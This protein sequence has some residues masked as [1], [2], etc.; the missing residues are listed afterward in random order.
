MVWDGFPGS[1]NSTS[2]TAIHDLNGRSFQMVNHT[3]AANVVIRGVKMGKPTAL[4][5]RNPLDSVCSLYRRWSFLTIDFCLDWYIKFHSVLLPYKNSIVVS[6]FSDTTGNLTAV[7][8]KINSKFGTSILVPTGEDMSLAIH[9]RM[10]K[11]KHTADV[12]HL[13]KGEIK[14][15]LKTR[16]KN[17]LEIAKSLYLELKD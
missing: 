7:V 10:G 13:S 4:V 6:D 5:I 1:A 3:H 16:Y 2:G 11:S 17:K 15:L 14:Q 9:K 8:E 12:S